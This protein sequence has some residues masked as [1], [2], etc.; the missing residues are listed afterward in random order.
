MLWIRALQ[1]FFGSYFEFNSFQKVECVWQYGFFGGNSPFFTL[2]KYK[3]E[4][5]T[6]LAGQLLVSMVVAQ[7]ANKAKGIEHTLYGVY[8]VGRLWYFVIL[9]DNYQY[10]KTLA[11]DSTKDDIFNTFC[12]LRQVKIYIDELVET[13]V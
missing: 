4:P 2:R 13:I 5:N 7:K 12:M 9:D 6:S 10:M 8:V 11:Y 1:F 3:V